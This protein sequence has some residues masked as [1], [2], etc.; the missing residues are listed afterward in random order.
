MNNRTWVVS[1]SH[2]KGKKYM[3]EGPN[4][5]VVHFG[6]EGMSDYL[7]HKDPERK[8]AYVLRMRNVGNMRD[9][10]TP[11]FWSRWFSWSYPEID[12]VVDFMENKF[13]IKLIVK[14]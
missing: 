11:S 12:E 6:A 1:E 3:A 5:V 4:G 7:Q 2:R 14:I 10:N 9:I 13:N 8:K